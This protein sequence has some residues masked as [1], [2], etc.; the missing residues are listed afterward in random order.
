LYRWMGSTIGAAVKVGMEPA[1]Y[2]GSM[3]PRDGGIGRDISPARGDISQ[4][5]MPPTMMNTGVQ[6]AALTFP[7]GDWTV[8]TAN[9]QKRSCGLYRQR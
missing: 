4:P 2:A 8:T 7:G 3:P 5:A 9:A 1:S 6:I